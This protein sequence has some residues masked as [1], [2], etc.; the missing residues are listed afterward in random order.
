MS[1]K[2]TLEDFQK[3]ADKRNHTVISFENYQ[4][5]HSNIPM[6]CKTCNTCFVTTVHK[7]KSATVTGCPECKRISTSK[8][9]KNKV[10]SEETKNKISEKAKKRTGS[11]LGRTGNRHPRY[12][13]GLARDFKNPSNSDF[14]WKN[15]V[16]KRCKYKCVITGDKISSGGRFACHHLNSFDIFE[17]QRYLPENGVL[18][19]REI[20]S[21]FHTNY[22]FGCNTEAQFAEFCKKFYN[23]NWEDR[24]KKL[25]L[26]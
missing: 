6:Y 14:A 3:F 17:D 24:K 22:K 15:A 11:L 9:H 10:T 20:H 26:I 2:L 4:D 25:G 5:V 13:G 23:I 21:L 19:K 12:K 1:K 7:Y 8:T 16:R 18:L